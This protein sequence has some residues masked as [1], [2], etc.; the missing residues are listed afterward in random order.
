M[1]KVLLPLRKTTKRSN[2]KEIGTINCPEKL[3]LLWVLYLIY[4]VANA[5]RSYA[6]NVLI[7][8]PSSTVN[9]NFSKT[10][11]CEKIISVSISKLIPVALQRLVSIHPTFVRDL[12]AGL[13]SQRNL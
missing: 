3:N 2:E 9:R 4:K 13:T 8:M 5:A 12:N 1:P 7:R 11:I 6:T 10:E